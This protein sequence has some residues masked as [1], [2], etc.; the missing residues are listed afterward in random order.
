MK[1]KHT[2]LV[3]IFGLYRSGTTLVSRLLNGDN[4]FASASDPIRPFFNAY[5]NFIR[6]LIG[7]K[8]NLFDPVNEGFRDSLDY[9]IR[10][11]G[12]DFGESINSNYISEIAGQ[13][14]SQSKPYS[15]VF[16]N[17]IKTD[18]LGKTFSTWHELLDYLIDSLLFCYGDE[19]QSALAVK[20]VWTLEM[21]APLLHHFKD[22]VKI[23]A[24][25]RDPADI[26]ASSKSSAGN[27]PLL[28]LA[29][30]WRKNIAIA[31][32]L[33]SC[34]PEQ[35]QLLQYE[36]L[37]SNPLDSYN[38][39]IKNAMPSNCNW[40]VNQ[41]P[42]PKADKGVLFSKNSSYEQKEKLFA[43]DS[44][45]I[46]KYKSVL[47]KSEVCWLKYLC[48]ISY[49]GD[50]KFESTDP[51]LSGLSVREPLELYPFRDKSTVANW[52]NTAYPYYDTQSFLDQHLPLEHERFNRVANSSSSELDIICSIL[53][54]VNQA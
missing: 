48:R 27:Y 6:N 8:N 4:R 43:I 42:I 15:P 3:F 5:S 49:L 19:G 32:F 31:Q 10:L 47:T 28:Y 20:E 33:K 41:L 9:Y 12:S 18:I 46:G 21:A 17:H 23:V 14:V 1:N 26:F 16:S 45:S 22:R 54:I 40:P 25:L 39:L 38:A 50:I 7:D 52:F 53:N 2:P 35:V 51:G 30:H 29:R 13:V 11:G 44:R 34:Y 36:K 37:C 24:V